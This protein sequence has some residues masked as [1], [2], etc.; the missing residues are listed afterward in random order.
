MV[1][2]SQYGSPW[3]SSCE[4][5][6]GGDGSAPLAE[7]WA[8]PGRN[9]KGQ[10]SGVLYLGHWLTEE[11]IMVTKEQFTL[12]SLQSEPNQRFNSCYLSVK[13]GEFPTRFIKQVR[14]EGHVS[15]PDESR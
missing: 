6:E 7:V 9:S 5:Q 3:P 4:L 12:S 10:T 15:V 8:D 11:E 2:W 1:N 14:F 13:I